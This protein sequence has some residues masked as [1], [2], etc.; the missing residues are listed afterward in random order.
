M[1]SHA[2]QLG[3]LGQWEGVIYA[4]DT[5]DTPEPPINPGNF[6]SLIRFEDNVDGGILLSPPVVTV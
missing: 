3:R 6:G 4:G 5:E 2:A 1:E